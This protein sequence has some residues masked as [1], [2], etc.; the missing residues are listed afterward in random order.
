MANNNNNANK[1]QRHRFKESDMA[2]AKKTPAKKTVAKKVAKPKAEP[3]YVMPME[4]K[5]WIEQAI[6]IAAAKQEWERP[7][8]VAHDRIKRRRIALLKQKLV[9]TTTA[10]ETVGVRTATDVVVS[11]GPR[12]R[13]I[14]GA[15]IDDVV[16]VAALQLAHLRGQL[17]QLDG[18]HLLRLHAQAQGAVEGARDGQGGAGAGP[19]RQTDQ[20]G[21]PP[22]AAPLGGDLSGLPPALVQVGT[23]E[24][25]YDDSQRFTE[26]STQQGNRVELEIYEQRWH[27]F[28]IHAGLLSGSLEA[29][30]RQAAFLRRQWAR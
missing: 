11:R 4:V 21:R 25:L 27:V 30:K 29:L 20:P 26:L 8:E 15:R 16:G 13:V 2:T 14:A 9:V 6:F 23:D 12:D 7:K 17:R 22:L 28:Q 1:H 19:H 24:L 3:T 18:G 5:N 10:S